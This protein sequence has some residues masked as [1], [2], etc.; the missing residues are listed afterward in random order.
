MNKF[1]SAVFFFL[2]TYSYAS[3]VHSVQTDEQ[4]LKEIE[5][6][7]GTP[8]T[9]TQFT[10]LAARLEVFSRIAPVLVWFLLCMLLT[11]LFLALNYKVCGAIFS[12]LGFS[13]L[14]IQLSSFPIFLEF[15]VLGLLLSVSILVIKIVKYFFP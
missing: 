10:E 6:V 8:D 11:I 14:L 3:S 2:G 1:L 5:R 13:L 7:G 4:L 9:L 15:G 12:F